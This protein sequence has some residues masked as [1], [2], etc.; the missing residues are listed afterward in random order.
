MGAV[1][2]DGSF[3]FFKPKRPL[4]ILF[5]AV[6]VSWTAIVGT[7]GIEDGFELAAGV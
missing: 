2:A 6:G 3:L 7:G 5:E 1:V 4:G